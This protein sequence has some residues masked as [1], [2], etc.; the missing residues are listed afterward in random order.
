MF[1]AML[2]HKVCREALGMILC[3]TSRSSLLSSDL[4][5]TRK[6]ICLLLWDGEDSVFLTVHIQK[7]QQAR[8]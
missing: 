8:T 5:M 1:P 3:S 2:V 6:D 7:L 4:T